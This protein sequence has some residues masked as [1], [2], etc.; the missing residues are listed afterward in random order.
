MPD[1]KTV[2]EKIY[3][4]QKAH[5]W[6]LIIAFIW[7]GIAV[8]LKEN[9][10]NNI[11]T[12]I[13]DMLFN[14]IIGA[15]SLQFLN[16]AINNINSGILPEFRHIKP[17]IFWDMIKLNIVWGMYAVICMLV[18]VLSYLM[19]HTIILPVIILASLFFIAIFVYY[20]YIA[21]AES[22]NTRGLYNIKLLFLFTKPSFKQTYKNLFL[23]I[24]LTII[25]AAVYILIYAV[26]GLFKI[27]F[28]L[29]DVIMQTFANYFLIVTWYLAFPYS[30]I[31]TYINI[32]KPIIGKGI[33]NG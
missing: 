31:N 29:F 25:I 7:A 21:Y 11:F 1:I 3:E 9:A 12:N 13:T 17:K 6:L 28:Y 33:Y 26:T 10:D 14:I 24:L 4:N 32:I 16:N 15:Y 30:L 23:Y 2:Y 22:L 5:L 19:V 8:T 20:I 18:S 27:N